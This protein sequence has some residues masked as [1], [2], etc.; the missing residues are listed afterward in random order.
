M[1]IVNVIYKGTILFHDGK[2]GVE[3]IILDSEGK[4]TEESL[5][6]SKKLHKNGS[7]GSVHE[8]ENPEGRT[9]K[10]NKFV[11]FHSDLSLASKY[12][13]ESEAN[14]TALKAKG[15]RLK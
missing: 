12:R 5:C 6:F 2:K 1:R 3:Y 4:Q 11:E 7:V 9:W 8:F 10:C 13:A 14:E 15:S